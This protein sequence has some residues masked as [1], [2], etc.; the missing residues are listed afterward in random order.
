MTRPDYVEGSSDNIVYY[1]KF[2]SAHGKPSKYY[3][4]QGWDRTAGH[5]RVRFTKNRKDAD[6]FT[7]RQAAYR[8]AKRILDTS[9]SWD[10]YEVFGALEREFDV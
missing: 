6:L 4:H 3:G 1:I 5:G 9:A 2:H 8:T 7:Q 10:S